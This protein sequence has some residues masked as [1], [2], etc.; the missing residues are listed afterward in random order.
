MASRT[1]WP[2]TV[3]TGD[4]VTEGNLDSLP[5]G[6]I[7]WLQRTTD[8]SGITAEADLSGMSQAV[9]VGTSRKIKITFTW[10]RIGSSTSNDVARLRIKEGSTQLHCVDLVNNVASVNENGGT[11]MTVLSAPSAGSHTYKISAERTV[12]TGTVTIVANTDAPM[13]LLIEDIGPA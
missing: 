11:M 4:V 12:G 2:G 9:T 13:Q 3:N 10:P 6:W 1:A 7:G 8:A 5:G